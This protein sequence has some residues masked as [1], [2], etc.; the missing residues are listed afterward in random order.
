VPPRPVPS[1]AP[2]PAT[3][4]T[5]PAAP[6]MD[7]ETVVGRYGAVAVAALTILMGVGAFVRWAIAH[8]RLGPEMRVVLGALGAAAVGAAGLWLRRRGHHRYG[9]IVLA[10]ALA[11]T[12]VVAWGAG[13]QLG[14]VPPEV[15]LGAAALTSAALAL[16]AWRGAEELLF[17]VGVGGAFIAPFVTSSGGG[18]PLVLLAFGWLVFLGGAAGVSG[19]PWRVANLVLSVA[20]SAYAGAAAVDI[21]TDDG[22]RSLA[23]LLFA[24]ACAWT[25]ILL[26]TERALSWA[27]RASLVA[28]ALLAL[29]LA[30]VDPPALLRL[31]AV[32]GTLT[33]YVRRVR[34]RHEWAGLV[35][36]G[37][38]VPLLF[39][40]AALAS[41][42]DPSTLPGAGHA[43]AWAAMAAGVAAQAG[44]ARRDPHAFV[45]ALCGGVALL[46]GLPDRLEVLAPSFAAYGAALVMLARRLRAPLVL[47]PALL[48]L[49]LGA[50]QAAELLTD[51]A[52]YA[53][54]PFATL[55]S[56]VAAVVVALWIAAGFAARGDGQRITLLRDPEVT[57]GARLW[58]A[59]AAVLALLWGRQELAY[60]YSRDIANFLLIAYYAVAGVGAIA[61]YADLK[62]IFTAA[63]ISAIGLR[64]GSYLLSGFFLL[65]VGYWAWSS[66]P[67][68]DGDAPRRAEP[69]AAPS[70]AG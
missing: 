10:L 22:L 27:I 48:S 65:A 35:V 1:P 38:A 30:D 16:L 70:R 41:F 15:A 49:L 12:H 25:A 37:V 7:I 54:T 44:P 50:A 56:L 47:V 11:M 45:A 46:L 23:P 3:R 34:V 57:V 20:V 63:Q 19:R 43:L 51:R 24:L 33:A 60:A 8:V 58:W 4:P 29:P 53:Y 66:R 40:C 59:A 39:L 21:G 62:A 61:V 6:E 64:V 36:E 31:A 14:V 42:D 67:A 69:D 55:P 13:P 18:S 68:D 2:R 32:V 26:E 5:P 17:V 52:W 9:S 28:A